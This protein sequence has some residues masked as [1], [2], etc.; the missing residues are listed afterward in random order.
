[1]RRSLL[2]VLWTILCAIALAH[3]VRAGTF[4]LVAT[5]PE[6]AAQ[7]TS[8]GRILATLKPFNGR[9]YAGYGDG[10]ANTGPITV[11]AFDPVAG[12]F[13]P[14][15]FTSTTEAIYIYREIDGQ[16]YAPNIDTSGAGG[17]GSGYARGTPSET[18]DVWEDVLPVTGLHMFDIN[19]LNGTDLLMV[20]SQGNNGAAFYSSDG[21]NWDTELFTPG[22]N[23]DF[24]RLHG[25]GRFDGKLYTQPWQTPTNGKGP[26]SLVFDGVTWTEGPNLLASVVW[27]PEEFAGQ[28]VYQG[29]FA[30]ITGSNLFKFDGTRA[31]NAYSPKGNQPSNFWDFS[32]DGGVLYGLLT[33][34][35][36]LQ[37]T[38]LSTWTPV[39]TAPLGSRS[40]AMLNGRLYVGGSQGDLYE[41]SDSVATFSPA[42]AMVFVPEPPTATMLMICVAIWPML[43]RYRR[44]ARCFRFR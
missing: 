4:E 19:T 22:R 7:A 28:M 29:N 2:H 40:L 43:A 33:S 12:D 25:S 41:Y 1:M 11:R 9:L 15:L 36:I 27:H 10:N 5:H 26:A 21:I 32:I 16:L 30:G 17:R 44:G 31:K 42:L 38:D 6:V 35:T 39:A 8:T 20:G 3:S 14:P 23:K 34:G 18:G 24:A 37:T 13:S